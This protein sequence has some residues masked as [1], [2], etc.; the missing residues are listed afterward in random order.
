MPFLE[1]RWRNN[2]WNNI[3]LKTFCCLQMLWRN[4]LSLSAGTNKSL[5]WRSDSLCFSSPPLH[6]HWVFPL[7]KNQDIRIWT[8]AAV[9]G[10]QMQSLLFR[11]KWCN[12]HRRASC[13]AEGAKSCVHVFVLGEEKELLL[14]CA[15]EKHWI[16]HLILCSLWF[17]VIKIA[18]VIIITVYCISLC[19]EVD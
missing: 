3:T 13:S 19:T 7:C 8:A 2:S 6:H 9:V 12:A 18:C 15:A 17:Y 11:G 16:K 10:K 1:I 5:L 14:L 4:P